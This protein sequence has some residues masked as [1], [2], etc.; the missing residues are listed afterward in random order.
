ME[1]KQIEEMARACCWG[2]A[3]KG[4][5]C[6]ECFVDSLYKPD[7]CEWKTKIA[8][9]LYNAGYRKQAWISVKDRLPNI[10]QE[11][12]AY[13]GEFRGDIIDR[14]TYLNNGLWEDAYGYRVSTEHE[15]ITHWTHLPE[16]PKGE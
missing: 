7:E 14:Y 15:G 2:G 4:Q 12:I 8:K 13:R 1:E 10:R 6:N 16:P 11:V 3:R 9:I 5:T